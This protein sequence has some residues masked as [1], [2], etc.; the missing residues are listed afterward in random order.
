[1]HGLLPANSDPDGVEAY[2]KAQPRPLRP[3]LVA[4]HGLLRDMAPNGVETLKWGYPTW[5]GTGNIASLMAF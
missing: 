2:I 1:M 3:I 4:A 5:V